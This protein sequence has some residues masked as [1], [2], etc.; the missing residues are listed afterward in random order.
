MALEDLTVAHFEPRVGDEF[1]IQ[2]PGLSEDLSAELIEVET[3]GSE[4]HEPDG[5]TPF[6]LVFR[7]P[8]EAVLPQGIYDLQHVDLG[9][10]SIFIVPIGRKDDGVRYQ[11]VF[12]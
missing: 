12:S 8:Q 3:I 5:R 9:P 7:V 2:V 6:S 4:P 10:L 11:A 1:T